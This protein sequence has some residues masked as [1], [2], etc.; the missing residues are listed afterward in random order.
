MLKLDQVK[1]DSPVRIHS[2]AESPLNTRLLEMGLHEGQLV[3]ILYRAPFGDPLAIDLGEYVLSL[4]KDEAELIA[5]TLEE[6]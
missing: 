2:M 3:K 6:E 4:R 1:A 5:V